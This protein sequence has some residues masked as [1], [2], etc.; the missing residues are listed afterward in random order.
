MVLQNLLNTGTNTLNSA[1]NY[2]AGVI[3]SGLDLKQQVLN[4]LSVEG[5]LSPSNI[6]STKKSLLNSLIPNISGGKSSNGQTSPI[7]NCIPKSPARKICKKPMPKLYLPKPTFTY[8]INATN[9]PQMYQKNPKPRKQLVKCVQTVKTY[10]QQEEDEEE[11]CEYDT[12]NIQYEFIDDGENQGMTSIILQT[13]WLGIAD[14]FP[15]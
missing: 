13:D 4:P 15:A 6:I 10:V 12:D 7:C 3:N 8:V 14:K 9:L 1:I 11:N 5:A 2:K